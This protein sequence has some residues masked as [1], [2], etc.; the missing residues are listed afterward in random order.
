MAQTRRGL[1]E[2]VREN[3]VAD[4]GEAAGGSISVDGQPPASPS[5]RVLESPAPNHQSK[6]APGAGQPLPPHL[7]TIKKTVHNRLLGRYAIEIDP[8]R[9]QEIQEKILTLLDEYLGESGTRLS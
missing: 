8:S 3:E 7:L 5:L 2:R 9:R 6:S 4:E 1:L